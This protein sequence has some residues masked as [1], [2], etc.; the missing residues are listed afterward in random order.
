MIDKPLDELILEGVEQPSSNTENMLSN[1]ARLRCDI[2]PL[3]RLSSMIDDK[4]YE[5]LVC[6]WAYTCLKDKKYEEVYRV[7]GSGDKGR[8]VLAYFDRTNGKY[9]L[10]Q[11]KHY[12]S[13]LTYTDLRG[14]IGKLIVYT[15]TKTYPIP[16]SYYLLCPNDVSQS[17]MD[18]LQKKGKKLKEKILEDWDAEIKRKVGDN[19]VKMDD[20]LK[21]YIE[22]FDFTIIK[23][24]EPIKFIEDIRKSNYYFYYFGGG[25]QMIKTEKLSIPV[26]PDVSERT[27]IQ[28]LN[29]AYS[30]NAGAEINALETS[31][32]YHNHLT[33]ARTSFYESEE[34]K[35]ASRKSTSPESDEFEDL[36]E[37]ILRYVG[38]ELDEDYNDG[39]EKVKKVES[40][41]GTYNPPSSMLIAHLV[42]SNV[43]A[44]ICHQLSNENEIIWKVK[45]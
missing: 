15:Y 6:V 36:K 28:N 19:W 35:I 40:K 45:E 39:F 21:S 38:N 8:D 24:I 34:V 16:Q 12:Q 37:S 23:K 11:C 22:G 13:A 2:P 4:T 10:Y 17:F 33:R 27:Y 20:S 42:D 3:Q 32:K 44:G 26:I 41:A 5:E 9:D 14:E 25:F 1:E 31:G 43:S 7:G 30:E 29:D 18:L